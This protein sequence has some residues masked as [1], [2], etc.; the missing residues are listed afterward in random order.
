MCST[1]LTKQQNDIQWHQFLAVNSFWSSSN[2]ENPILL[3]DNVIT[4]SLVMYTVLDL[5]IFSS[6]NDDEQL[7]DEMSGFDCACLQTRVIILHFLIAYFMDVLL[8]CF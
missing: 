8:T 1:A 5:M 6:Y 4:F 7:C 2:R 3:W